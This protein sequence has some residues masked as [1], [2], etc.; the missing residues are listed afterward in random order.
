MLGKFGVA[1]AR[2]LL[3]Y[4]FIFYIINTSIH[5]Y[6]Y[7][8]TVHDVMHFN[9]NIVFNFLLNSNRLNVYFI[10]F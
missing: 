9:E 7:C 5:T 3:S 10:F 4:A 2:E 6:G 8:P 1:H